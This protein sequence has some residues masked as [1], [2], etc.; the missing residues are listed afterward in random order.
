MKIFSVL[1]LTGAAA[2]AII[3]G[4]FGAWCPETL[5]DSSELQFLVAALDFA[6]GV[7]IYCDM[8][9]I[10]IPR[11]IFGTEFVLEVPHVGDIGELL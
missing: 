7:L 3:C 2:Y 8:S 4:V 9:L 1:L 10:G 11:R 5:W 6:L